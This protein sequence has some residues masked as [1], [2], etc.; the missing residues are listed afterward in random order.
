MQK[1]EPTIINA[2]NLKERT[3]NIQNETNK[4]RDSVEDRLSKIAR[5]TVNEVSRRKR[6][7]K[8]KLKATSQ[9]ERIHFWK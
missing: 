5:Q 1:E 2:L 8:D 9:K 3:E 4:I 6:I 7:A